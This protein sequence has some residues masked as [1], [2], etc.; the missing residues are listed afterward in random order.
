[1]KEVPTNLPRYYHGFDISDAQ[2]PPHP[3]S[4]KYSVQDAMKAFEPQHQNRYDL[5][6]VR[7]IVGAI[8]ESAFDAFVANLIT[9]LSK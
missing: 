6:Q 4:I 3:N 9:L 8:Q 1:M 5:V 2:F 7:L